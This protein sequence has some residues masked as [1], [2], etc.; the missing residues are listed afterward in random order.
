MPLSNRL[1]TLLDRAREGEPL[2]DI[3]CDHGYLAEEAVRSRRFPEVHFVD[4]LA[5]QIE[6]IRRR[7][8]SWTGSGTVWGLHVARAEDLD[9]EI[10]GN[11]IIAGMGGDRIWSI[12]SAWNANGRLHPGRLIFS[13][14]KDVPLLLERMSAS[15]FRLVE[16]AEVQERGRRRPVLVYEPDPA[17]I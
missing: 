15:G 14:H 17:K 3:G 13:P 10:R 8:L 9:R 7:S 12:L 16:E 11:V 1:R 6:A 4:P 5:H 2:W